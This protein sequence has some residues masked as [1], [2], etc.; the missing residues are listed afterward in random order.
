MTNLKNSLNK[1]EGEKNSEI[2]TEFVV[3][4]F[5]KVLQK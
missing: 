5:L 4:F 2:L 1:K 3:F